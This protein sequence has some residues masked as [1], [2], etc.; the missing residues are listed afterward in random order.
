MFIVPKPPGV[1]V[2]AIVVPNTPPMTK[3]PK[4]QENSS[5]ARHACRSNRAQAYSDTQP[6]QARYIKGKGAA[7]PAVVTF[8]ASAVPPTKRAQ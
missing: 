7:A 5:G 1:A 8:S 6:F 3:P 2:P 4:T